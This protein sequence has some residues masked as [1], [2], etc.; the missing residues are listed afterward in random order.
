MTRFTLTLA[1]ASDDAALR[2]RM[3]EDVMDGSIAVTFR[4]EPRYFAGTAIQGAEAEVIK[5][6]D[7][8]SARIVGLAT[9][10]TLPA[11]INGQTQSLGYLCDLR[12]SPTIRGGT[13]L[14]RGF[15]MLKSLH[16]AAPVDLYYTMILSDNHTAL[17]V[18]TSGRTSLPSYQPFGEI[19]TPAVHLDQPR[20]YTFSKDLRIVKGSAI[21]LAEIIDFVNRQ[22]R[23]KQFAPV[24][25]LQDFTGPRLSGLQRDDI[26]VA[27]AGDRIVGCVACWDQSHV[28]QIFVE[29]YALTH[30]LA[31]PFY[32]F[33]AR[34]T[35]R[36]P[37]PRKGGRLPFFYLTWIAID[38]DDPIVFRELIEVVYADR[39]QGPWHFFMAGLHQNN[40]LVAVLRTFRSIAA[41]GKLFIVH[42]DDGR[43]AFDQLDQRIP[44]IEIAAL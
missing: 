29:N 30:R 37:L 21:T 24:Y 23:Q 34:Y 7:S 38:G 10:A 36:K 11:Y 32:N 41:A 4:R 12:V 27:L 28:R 15:K 17:D 19:F 22:Y 3:A 9:R 25:R 6:V 18:L 8:E 33:A 20:R 13:L 14:A 40:P 44:H 31:R 39:R 35:S 1:E 42:W 26:Y 16:D 5:C 43:A 2:Q